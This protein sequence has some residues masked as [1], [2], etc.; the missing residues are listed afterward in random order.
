V[1]NFIPF[2][3]AI[4]ALL[5]AAAAL[6]PATA[7]AA[8]ASLE[9][10][11]WQV[12]AA[13]YGYFAAIKGTVNYPGD[14]RSTDFDVPFHKLLDHL[15]M[16]FMGALG[17]H[18][19]RWGMYIDALYMDLG[20]AKSQTRNF[21]VGNVTFPATADLSLDLKAWVATL[22]GDYRV[23]SDPKWTVDLLV[24]ARMLYLNPSLDFTII[25]PGGAITG[26]KESSNTFWDGIVGIKGRYTFG[27]NGKWFVPFY[28]DVGTGQTQLTW[29]G[30]AGIGYSF[31]WGDLVAAYRYLDW[32]GKSG[33]PLA[34]LN[35]GGPMVGVELH[36]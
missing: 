16:G 9:S 15:K 11:Q 32:N 6:V 7:Q 12:T 25:S 31:H 13:L 36:W 3:R 5:F 30:L 19:G 4:I 24:G 23:V 18:N 10:D 1:K 20:A 8:P 21:S 28:L 14:L 34:N 27:D 29:Q 2:G 22:A 35:M 26:S 33:E 17:V